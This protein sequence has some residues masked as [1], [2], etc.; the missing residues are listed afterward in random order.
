[1][2]VDFYMRSYRTSV[3]DYRH[4]AVPHWTAWDKVSSASLCAN[5]KI[6]LL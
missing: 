4:E 1:M 3:I 6:S 5:L 2:S